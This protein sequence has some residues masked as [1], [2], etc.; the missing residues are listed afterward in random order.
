M[1]ETRRGV[2]FLSGLVTPDIFSQ[3]T[4]YLT[5]LIE[6][7]EHEEKER[8]AWDTMKVKKDSA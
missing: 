8:T 5:P 2:Y 6:E 7:V 1:A 4:R 3:D